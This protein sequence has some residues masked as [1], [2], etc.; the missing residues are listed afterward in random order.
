MEE[1]RSYDKVHE[2]LLIRRKTIAALSGFDQG[3][4]PRQRIIDCP[5]RL[6]FSERVAPVEQLDAQHGRHIGTLQEL[7]QDRDRPREVVPHPNDELEIILEDPHQP[8]VRRRD[9]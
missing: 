9:I 1:A 7:R 8:Y 2:S 5:M 4:S 6:Q 3:T